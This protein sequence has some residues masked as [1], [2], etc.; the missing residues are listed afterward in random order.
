MDFTQLELKSDHANRPLLACADVRIF[1]ETFFPLYKQ[2]YDFL[3]AVTE[4][5]C[6]HCGKLEQSVKGT[7]SSFSTI[8]GLSYYSKCTLEPRRQ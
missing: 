4:P 6:R 3:V 5:V 8:V 7:Y 2:A 1:L